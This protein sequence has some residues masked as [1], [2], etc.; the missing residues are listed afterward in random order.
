MEAG[1]PIER[2]RERPE[3]SAVLCDIDGT[4]APIVP[5]PQAAAVPEATRGALRELSGRYLLVGC[6]SGRRASVARA[7]VGLDE[8]AYSGNH[9]LELLLPGEVEPRLDPALGRRGSVAAGVPARPMAN[10]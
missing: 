8:L 7:L 3:R 6:V 9:G 4:L 10:P 2:L 1:S 5:D